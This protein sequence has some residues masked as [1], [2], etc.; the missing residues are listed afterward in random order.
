MSDSG[1]STGQRPVMPPIPTTSFISHST[2]SHLIATN[3]AQGHQIL[4]PQAS[5]AYPQP[6]VTMG[7]G[8]PITNADNLKLAEFMANAQ[9]PQNYQDLSTGHDVF[10]KELEGLINFDL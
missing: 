6:N 7:T 10:D 2:E 9:L 3:N 5:S 8:A 1:N 4:A